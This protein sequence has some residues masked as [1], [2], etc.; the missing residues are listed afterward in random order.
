MPPPLFVCS[1]VDP[2]MSE[3]QKS[4]GLEAKN[5]I[6]SWCQ[7]LREKDLHECS[8][9]GIQSFGKLKMCLLEPL[10]FSK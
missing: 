7:T 4:E 1:S 10:M 5:P 9:Q 3:A 8:L 6:L 2:H